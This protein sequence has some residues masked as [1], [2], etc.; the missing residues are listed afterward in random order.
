MLMSTMT[1]PRI[2][3]MDAMRWEMPLSGICA[4]GFSAGTGTASVD[5]ISCIP[6]LSK[7]SHLARGPFFLPDSRRTN[8]GFPAW[9]AVQRAVGTHSCER[10]SRVLMRLGEGEHDVEGSAKLSFLTVMGVSLR[11]P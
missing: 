5:F 3:S 8:S 11:G 4:G 7:F 6:A 2:Q 1:K 9:S 10:R